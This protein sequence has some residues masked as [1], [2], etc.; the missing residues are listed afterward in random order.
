MHSFIEKL[1]FFK[2]IYT[3]KNRKKQSKKAQKNK[4]IWQNN[5]RKKNN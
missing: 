2:K 3:K 4:P 5:P 1:L